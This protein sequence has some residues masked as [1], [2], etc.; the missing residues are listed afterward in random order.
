MSDSFLTPQDITCLPKQDGKKPSLLMHTCCGPCAEYP[1]AAVQENFDVTLFFYNPNIHPLKEWYRRLEGVIRLAEILDLPLLAYP[2]CDPASWAKLKGDPRTRCRGCYSSRLE[3]TAYEAEQRNFAYISTTL[4][5]SPYQQHQQLQLVGEA[6]AENH[7]V[8]FF[9]MDFRVGFRQGQ[10][11]A[12]MHGLY[13]Q[14]YCGCCC[15]LASSDFYKKVV[16]QQDE[17]MIPGQLA[18]RLAEHGI[19]QL[20]G[21]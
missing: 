17:Y 11:M 4:L 21:K 18:N 5:V 19:L 9:Y 12:K 6:M 13:R 15:S 16:K 3:R 7:G 20:R 10:E 14:K 1:I 2:G 8:K